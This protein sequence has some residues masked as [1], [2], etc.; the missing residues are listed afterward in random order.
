M[1]THSRILAGESHGQRSLA[2]C[3]RWGRRESD[4]ELSTERTH[5]AHGRPVGPVSLENP[6][7]AWDTCC[8]SGAQSCLTLG[9][10]K[11]CSTPGLPVPHHVPEFAQTH[12]H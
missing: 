9:K 7:P 10:L 3:S 12:V 11:D 2:G 4:T 1:A 8:C 5:G 6:D